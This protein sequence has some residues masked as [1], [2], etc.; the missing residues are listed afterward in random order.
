MLLRAIFV[1]RVVPE[2]SA[3]GEPVSYR[4]YARSAQGWR[5]E[6]CLIH[7]T[8]RELI[9]GLLALFRV[10]RLEE[11]QG[12]TLAGYIEGSRLV[13]LANHTGNMA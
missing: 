11:L 6:Y 9:S 3:T 4:V 10:N 13:R 1:E 8:N 7:C 5:Y 12:V 2:R